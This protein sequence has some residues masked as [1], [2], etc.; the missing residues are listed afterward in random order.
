M[1]A[2]GFT[3]ASGHDLFSIET[4]EKSS[5]ETSNVLN[6]NEVRQFYEH[7]IK[8]GEGQDV[9]RRSAISQKDNG[10]EHQNKQRNRESSRRARRRARAAEMQQGQTDS[11]VHRVM[12][13]ESEANPRRQTSNSERT[14]ELL[15]LRLLRCAHDGDISGVK[16]LLSKGVDINFQV[17][18]LLLGVF[19]FLEIYYLF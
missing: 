3:P 15:G 8:D 10:R 5:C 18:Y 14:M 7:L 16:D 1:A 9:S 13:G 19:S 6:G 17:Q 2:L 11:V 4:T 12:S